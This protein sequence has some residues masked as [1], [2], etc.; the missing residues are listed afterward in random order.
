MYGEY[1]GFLNEFDLEY[2]QIN[3]LMEVCI[4]LIFGLNKEYYFDLVVSLNS[5]SYAYL[6]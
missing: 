6:K 3:K 2:L 4:S 1:E 5:N